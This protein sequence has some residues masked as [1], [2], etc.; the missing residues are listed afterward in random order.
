MRVRHAIIIAALVFLPTVAHAAAGGGG[1]L[2]W[3]AP[4]PRSART[5]GNLA[6]SIV[7][8]SDVS[9]PALPCCSLVRK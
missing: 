8:D 5:V 9:Q 7:P 2:P 4:I 6:F 3:D 1:A